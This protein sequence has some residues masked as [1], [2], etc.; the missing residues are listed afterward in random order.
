MVTAHFGMSQLARFLPF[1]EFCRRLSL[2]CRRM[3]HALRDDPRHEPTGLQFPGR[4]FKK[5]DEAR[6]ARPRTVSSS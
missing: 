1:P 5:P 3:S 4:R 6:G 2:V